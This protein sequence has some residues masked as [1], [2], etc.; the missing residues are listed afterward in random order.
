MCCASC[1]SPGQVKPVVERSYPLADAADA[2][3]AIGE[4]HAQ[5]KLV[6]SL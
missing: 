3:R 6:V 4:G 5:G 2:L 1:S